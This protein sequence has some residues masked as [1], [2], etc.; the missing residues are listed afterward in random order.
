MEEKGRF[1]KSKISEIRVSVD[2]FEGMD[3]VDIREWTKDGQPTKKGIKFRSGF[4]DK[5][6]DILKGLK[7]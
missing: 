3:I 5:L 2:K 4:V 7:I 1:E 6:V